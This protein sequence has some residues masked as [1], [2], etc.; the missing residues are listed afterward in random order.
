MNKGKEKI[1]YAVIIVVIIAIFVGAYFLLDNFLFGKEETNGT[2]Y[3]QEIT[4]LEVEE[5]LT[6]NGLLKYDISQV[7]KDT[8]QNA[9]YIWFNTN[10]DYEIVYN[11]FNNVSDA[12]SNYNTNL[13]LLDGKYNNLVELTKV[14]NE[15]Y[16]KYE[17][18]NTDKYVMILRIGTA[19]FQVETSKNN[20]SSVQNIISGL[21][22]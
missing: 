13:S 8:K 7:L 20:K 3:K 4:T 6:Q 15:N 14:E 19:Y 5:K 10:R 2:S 22:S 12:I 17:A 1:L 11:N 9:S 16:A 18:E 21:E